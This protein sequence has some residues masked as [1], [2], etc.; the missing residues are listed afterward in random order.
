MADKILIVDDIDVNLQLIVDMLSINK[1]YKLLTATNGSDA[2]NICKN[3]LPDLVL[4]DWKMPKMTGME[5]LKIL[6]EDEKTKDIPVLM[7]TAFASPESLGE[8]FN[9]GAVDYISKPINSTELTSRINSALKLSHSLQAVR[10]QN[11]KISEQ[12]EELNRLAQVAKENEEL[13][14]QKH[15]D[16]LSL[17]EYL[18]D[19]NNTLE[20]QKKEINAQKIAIEEEQQKSETLLLNIL[21]FEVARQ[22]KSKGKA[23]PRHYRMVSVLFTDFKGFSTLSKGLVPRELINILDS[24]FIKYDEIVQENYMEKIKTIGDAYMCVGGL[25]L[26]NKSNP[27]NAVL[28]GMQIQQYMNKMNDE[29][30]LNNEPVW[31]LRVGIHT[32]EVIAGVVGKFKF[33]Y[34]VWG[35]TVNIA[36]RME[37]AGQ[38]GMVN[39][40]GATYEYVKDYFDCVYR[41]K[42]EAKNIGKI[43]M[44]FV[45]GIKPELSIDGQCLSPNEEFFKL[46]NKL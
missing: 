6:K 12:V 13:L 30:V 11:K 39:I 34:D 1:D 36:S 41:G 21:P 7:I 22:L 23:S 37:A 15:E 14:D 46:L 35:T 9:S 40:S 19:A 28:A 26:S 16:M 4:M 17:T 2:I 20:E 31:E 5:A 33:A 45:T 25:P 10:Q 44:Y 32:G 24:Y 29:K 3:Q 18:E 42:V 43:D 27:I 38:V 8:A